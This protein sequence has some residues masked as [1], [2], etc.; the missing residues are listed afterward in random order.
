MLD[1]KVKKIARQLIGAEFD[2]R[3][4]QLNDEIEA[5]QNKLGLQGFGMSDAL[6]SEQA[7]LLARELQIRTQIAVGILIRVLAG[8]GIEPLGL[9][10]DLKKELKYHLSKV[11]F[12]FQ[13]IL[14]KSAHLI[15]FPAR[16]DILSDARR[17]ATQ[18]ANAE[19]DLFV[20]SRFKAKAED[21]TSP[22]SIMNIGTVGSIQFGAGSIANVVQN[23]DIEDKQNISKALDLIKDVLERESGRHLPNEDLRELI[24]DAE[25]ETTKAKPN[26]LRLRTTLSAIATTI[27]TTA[28]L[29][30][31]YDLIKATLVTFGI[32]L[33]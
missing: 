17:I 32:A 13:Q 20:A 1:P 25:S 31:A 9:A 15:N 23:L 12:E 33:P 4:T 21:A 5:M 30:G 26:M 19:I 6:T 29:Q 3:N 11:D 22:Q 10:A 7:K 27:Q 16:T 8:I 24:A 2:A 14:D 28:S 18:K